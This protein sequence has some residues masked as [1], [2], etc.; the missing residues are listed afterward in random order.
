MVTAVVNLSVDEFMTGISACQKATF[1]ASVSMPLNTIGYFGTGWTHWR[2]VIVPLKLDQNG[3]DGLAR[4]YNFFLDPGR[5][6]LVIGAQDL[7]GVERQVALSFRSPA[8]LN[9]WLVPF[10]RVGYKRNTRVI[11]APPHA[12]TAEEAT[13]LLLRHL[14]PLVAEIPP[15]GPRSITGFR[16]LH[17]GKG[18]TLP[19]NAAAWSKRKPRATAGK[20]QRRMEMG[21]IIDV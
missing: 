15:S 1:S 8:A 12:A 9:H 2:H 20:S 21:V 18:A 7:L 14:Q 4:C 3:A 19:R 17:L 5:Y 13:D 10:M 6:C 11:E 16:L